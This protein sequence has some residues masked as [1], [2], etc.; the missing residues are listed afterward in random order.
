MRRI[1]V[2]DSDHEMTQVEFWNFYKY[3]WE[4][5]K[6]K[7]PLLMA[8]EV[9]KLVTSVFPLASATMADPEEGRPQ[10]FVL[11]GIRRRESVEEGAGFTCQWNNW[12]CEE[13]PFETPQDLFAHV[14]DHIQEQGD[15]SCSWSACKYDAPSGGL[16]AHVATHIPSAKRPKRPPGQTALPLSASRITDPVIRS[17]PPARPFDL[18]WR[19]PREDPPSTSFAAILVLRVL[20]RTA[21]TGGEVVLKTDEDHFGF[22]GVEQVGDGDDPRG[23]VA[24]EDLGYDEFEGL[25]KGKKAFSGISTL[26]NDVVLSDY[27]MAGWVEEIIDA[28]KSESDGSSQALEDTLET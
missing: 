6:D 23:D 1:F 14:L 15:S 27:S 9:I 13:T 20:F 16:R 4:P 25:G 22:P 11:R 26:L 10:R 19:K 3:S 24:V 5:Y 2:P 18:L 17:P 8:T 21:F 12:G 28:I 7:Q